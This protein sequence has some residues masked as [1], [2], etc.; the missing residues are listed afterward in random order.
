MSRRADNALNAL[1]DARAH[2]L[3]QA[4]LLFNPSPEADSLIEQLHGLDAFDVPPRE[5][6]TLVDQ[7]V[8]LYRSN[9]AEGHR[10][11]DAAGALDGHIRDLAAGISNDLTL[12]GLG[13]QVRLLLQ[14][15]DECGAAEA[16][17]IRRSLHRLCAEHRERLS[18]PGFLAELGGPLREN[19]L[20]VRQLRALLDGE[21]GS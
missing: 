7:A 2:N 13:R 12:K 17:M 8:E 6:Q 1:L 18:M 4:R 10:E 15:L 3:E 14:Q 19:G 20:R 16:R 9:Q 5:V 21:T 11:Q